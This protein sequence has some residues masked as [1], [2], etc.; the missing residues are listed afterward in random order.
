MF[1]AALILAGLCGRG[2]SL[3]QADEIPAK[4]EH[5]S[6]HQT[7]GHH[8]GHEFKNELGLIFAGTWESESES[9]VFT[10]GAEYVRELTGRLDV[11]GVVEHLAE[12]DAWVF[13]GGVG[14]RPFGHDSM[15]APLRVNT[16]PG[17]EHKRRLIRGSE[18]GGEA[19]TEEGD[20]SENLFLW[21]VGLSYTFH[22]GSRAFVAP[23]VDLDFVNEEEE[24]VEAVVFGASMGYLF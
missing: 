10:L 15:L 17:L 13:V 11:L 18:Q 21:R 23:T 2:L 7:S 5:P 16:G 12:A 8:E 3:A 19:E 14:I 20:T 4:A 22:T 6:D 24:W 9:T 1:A